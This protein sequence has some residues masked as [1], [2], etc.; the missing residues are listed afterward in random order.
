MEFELNHK[1]QI[2]V[3]FEPNANG[4][5]YLT[6]TNEGNGAARNVKF[7][8]DPPL[9]NSKGLDVSHFSALDKGINF[10]SAKKKLVYLFD[11]VEAIGQYESRGLNRT[12]NLNIEYAWAIEGKSAITDSYPLEL[13]TLTDTQVSSYKDTRTLIDEVEKIRMIFE[14]IPTEN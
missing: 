6:I 12:F 9:K 7:S 3:D 14:K 4:L 1:P 13:A 2:I 5:Y 11:S 8:I 10:F